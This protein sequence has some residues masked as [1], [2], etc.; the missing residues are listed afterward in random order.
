MSSEHHKS[1]AEEMEMAEICLSEAE[2]ILAVSPR[3]AAR[4]AYLSML[5]AA[6]ARIAATGKKVPGTHKGVNMVIGDIYRDTD[7]HAQAMLVENEGWK[8]AADYG[9]T[10]TATPREAKEAIDR[11]R[12][13]LVRLKNDI[14]PEMLE[15]GIEPAILETIEAK[16]MQTA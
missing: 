12:T 14:P 5:H 15:K 8:L 1:T 10:A 4:E 11:A 7:F 13:F 2:D 16:S 6:H 9:R 3:V